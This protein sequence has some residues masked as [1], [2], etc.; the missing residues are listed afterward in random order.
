M[1]DYVMN[2]LLAQKTGR[3]SVSIPLRVFS[4]SVPTFLIFFF[5]DV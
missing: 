5:D 1:Q 2:G 4:R 3:S